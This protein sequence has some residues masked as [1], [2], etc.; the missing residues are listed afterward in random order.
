MKL[1]RTVFVYNANK[2]GAQAVAR[3]G[4]AWCR[5]NGI[6]SQVTSR[7]QF[8]CREG[9]LAV[10][11][12]GDGTLLRVASVLYPEQVPVLGVHMGS[13]GFLSSCTADLLEEA[14][15]QAVAGTAQVEPRTRIAARWGEN[16]QTALN[17]VVLMG[18]ERG[19]LARMDVWTD[20]APLATLA[21]DGLIA[22]SP[23]GASA[24][25]LACGGP[26]LDPQVQAL[27][28]VPVAPHRLGAR[29]VVLPADAH[30]TVHAQYPVTVMLDGDAAGE[31]QPGQALCLSLASAPTLLVDLLGEPSYFQRLRD[32]LGWLPGPAPKGET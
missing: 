17:D 10:A 15:Q 21:G 27:L 22:A 25:A 5:Q 29:P 9:D 11:V 16:E 3:R 14:L 8:R 2:P 6:A 7:R 26:V 4:A 24:Y 20:D 18:S 12:G 1:E 30:V 31:V 23:T 13:L 28:L 32:K 19:R